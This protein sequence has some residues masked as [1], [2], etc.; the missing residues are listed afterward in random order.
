MGII[1]ILAINYFVVVMNRPKAMGEGATP[2]RVGITLLF[3]ALL[4]NF[5]QS[6]VDLRRG[7]EVSCR[8]SL[9]RRR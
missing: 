1:L 4:A 3:I 9:I 2:R 7:W 8:L 6:I 5:A